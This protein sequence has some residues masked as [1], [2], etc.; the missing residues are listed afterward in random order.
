VHVDYLSRELAKSIEVEVHCWG[1]Q[2][3]DLGNLQVRGALPWSE[4]STGTEEKFKGALEAF[5][6]NLTQIKALKGVDIAHT[7]T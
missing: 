7:H 6:L 4:I 3:E 1:E 2:H 5:S